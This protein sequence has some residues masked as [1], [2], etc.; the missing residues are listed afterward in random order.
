LEPIADWG[1]PSLPCLRRE[2][3]EQRVCSRHWSKM[4]IPGQVPPSGFIIPW[5]EESGLA[6][7]GRVKIIL[8]LRRCDVMSS[9]AGKFLIARLALQE[10]S[11]R[12]T[13]VLLLQHGV[14]GAFGLV[15]NR[16]V[17][18]EGLPFPVFAGG[19]CQSQ[20]LLML[21]GH[22]DWAESASETP[23]E[24]APGV[25]L[26]DA[27]CLSQIGD[28]ATGPGLRYRMFSG[29][30]GWGPGQLEGELAAGAWAIVPATG[31]LL[32]DVPAEDLWYRLVPPTIPEPSV[33]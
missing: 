4:K 3:R 8:Q 32:F 20:G 21:H 29:Y 5:R 2:T 33:N 7:P 26:G 9:Y 13:V 31:Q 19:P 1:T 27:S 11:F 30:A 14:E 18:V 24:V 16:A 10:A 12:Q 17:T 22:A 28:A 15:V 23:R 6:S 25:F